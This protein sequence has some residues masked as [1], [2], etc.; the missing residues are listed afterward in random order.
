MEVDTLPTGRKRRPD[1]HAE[2]DSQAHLQ[3]CLG[4][5]A[6]STAQD[7]GFAT[8]GAAGSTA[9]AQGAGQPDHRD[10]RD[11]AALLTGFGGNP[12]AADVAEVFCPG[13]LAEHAHLF[14]LTPGLAADLRTGWGLVD[15]GGPER[16]LEAHG[17]RGP[18]LHPR[19][20]DV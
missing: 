8:A 6:R 15:P 5:A 3:R 13:R 9:P 11:I 2:E 10:V 4:P 20:T 16:V 12:N 14:G 7:V 17:A 19:F 18:L 1:E